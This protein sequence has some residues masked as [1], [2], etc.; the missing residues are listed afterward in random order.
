M[1]DIPIR[2]FDRGGEVYADC[3][4]LD[5]MGWGDTDKEAVR[6]VAQL[7]LDY[8]VGR[9]LG[10]AKPSENL[11]NKLLRIAFPQVKSLAFLP[12]P[13]DEAIAERAAE[14]RRH[15]ETP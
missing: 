2:L 1:P 10:H 15:H 4:V 11:R 8:Y 7:I 12:V 14:I 13:S 5:L 6:Y 9:S 3:E